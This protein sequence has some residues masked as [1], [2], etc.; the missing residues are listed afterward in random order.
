M[1]K[2]VS[3]TLVALLLLSLFAGCS[4]QVNN[5]VVNSTLTDYLV[6]E[7]VGTINRDNFMTNESGLTYSDN[8]MYGIISYEGLNDTGAIYTECTSKRQYFAVRTNADY[9]LNKI[10]SLNVYGLV[11]GK[12]ETLIPL[13]YADFYFISDRYVVAYTVTERTFDEDEKAVCKLHDYDADDSAEYRGSWCLYDLTTG[14]IVPGVTGTTDKTPISY[15]RYVVYYDAVDTRFVVDENGK[16][17]PEDAK[18]FDDGSYSIEGKTGTVYGE[19]GKEL[20]AY[21]LTG[22]IP[23]SITYD[24]QYYVASQYGDEG[25]KYVVMDKTGAVISAE[26]DDYFTV[27]GDLL[28]SENKIYNFEGKNVLEGDYNS[29]YFDD[30][31]GSHWIARNDKAYTMI[32]KNGG[33]YFAGVDSKKETV[34]TGD[35]VANVKKDDDYYYYS[36]KDHDY[37]IK[38]YNFAPWIV[39]TP[40]VNGRYDLIDTMTGKTLLE[41]YESYSYVARNAFAY[42][43][44][45]KYEGGADVY[46]IISSA[47][48]EEYTNKKTNLLDDLIAAFAAEGINVTIDK[49]SGEMA[50]DSSV[51]FGGDSAELTADG[52][53]FLNKFIKVYTEVAFSEKY[54]GFISKTMVEGHT[55]P[56]SGSTYAS[57]L[58]LSEQRAANVKAYCLSAET[59]VNVSM[60]ADTL[61]DVGYGNSQPIQNENGEVNMEASRRVSFRF[62]I[63]IDL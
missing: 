53:A 29:L 6:A 31:F 25:T 19:D 55:A 32:D 62:L 16:A 26:F 57:S 33:V 7:K 20:F 23:S 48:M 5:N 1:K 37:T 38:G 17:L 9:S 44:F 34:Y 39:K 28:I 60:L 49:E 45:A 51:L 18:L 40:S 15:G 46:L 36:H 47:Q 35:F 21:D 11:N 42:Y 59:G 58:P 13:K 43:V 54:Q 12:G 3:L 24:R 30:M 52:K 22:F 61:E 63:A 10:E 41:G 14:K 8:G 2:Y 27:Y 50:L 56:V 4:K